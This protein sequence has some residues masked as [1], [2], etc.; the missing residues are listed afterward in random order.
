MIVACQLNMSSPMG[1]ALQLEGGSFV[2][3]WSSLLMRFNAM[4]ANTQNN[5]Q[6]PRPSDASNGNRDYGGRKAASHA[7]ITT[8][9][10]RQ[11]HID[12]EQARVSHT[13]SAKNITEGPTTFI[14]TNEHGEFSAEP[15]WQA[16]RNRHTCGNRAKPRQNQQSDNTSG[17]ATPPTTQR[18][19]NVTWG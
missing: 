15:R 16:P 5:R 4:P 3:S 14:A 11:P 8:V 7:T 13:I 12:Q 17:K 1:P 2:K 19:L 6:S 9:I 10:P 18:T